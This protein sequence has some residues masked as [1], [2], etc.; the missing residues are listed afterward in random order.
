MHAEKLTPGIQRVNQNRASWTFKTSQVSTHPRL[1]AT[2]ESAGPLRACGVHGA[3]LYRIMALGLSLESFAIGDQHN[4]SG[5]TG[6]EQ[7]KEARN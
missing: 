2:L 3:A 4:L 6:D 1:R 7:K 5:K